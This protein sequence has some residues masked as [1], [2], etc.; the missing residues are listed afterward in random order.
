VSGRMIRLLVPT[1][2]TTAATL[3][4]APRR[5]TLGAVAFLHNGQPFY[6][7]IAPSLLASLQRRPGLAVRSYR[8][9]R[10]SSPVEPAVLDEIVAHGGAAVVGLAC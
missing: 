2:D 5:P 8:K 1:A 9:P 6:D 10:Y 7:R 4:A 3:T